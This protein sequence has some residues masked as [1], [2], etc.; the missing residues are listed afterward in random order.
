M[1][2]VE[3][4]YVSAATKPYTRE[5]LLE[6]LGTARSHNRAVGVTG[7]LLYDEGS[8]LQVLEGD[9]RDVEE[10][11]R[12]IIKDGAHG[13]VLVLSRRTITERSFSEWSMGGLWVTDELGR[14]L[15]ISSYMK[16]N[17]H[18]APGAL[19]TKVLEAFRDGRYRRSAA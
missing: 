18:L 6:L 10:L 14:E 3:L 11:Y 13:G 9:P 2:L 5:R 16:G 12:H 1:P 15:G 19:V 17:A 8:F 7:V 4:V